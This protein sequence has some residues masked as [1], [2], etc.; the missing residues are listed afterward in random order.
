MTDLLKINNN[1]KT[2][3]SIELCELINRIRKEEGVKAELRHDTLL[4]KIKNE[5]EDVAPKFFGTTINIDKLG[6]EHKYPCYNLPQKE[7]LQVIASESKRVRRRLID[8]IERL[9]MENQEL[10][11]Q[12]VP[13]TFKEALLL[14][15]EQQCQIEEQQKLI[16]EQKPKVEFYDEV[17][18][19][20][21]Y[22]D[23]SE[24][25]KCLNK[26]IGR[27]KL[28]QI[29]REQGILRFNNE[30]YQ[31]YVDNGFFKIET[32]S[33]KKNGETRIYLKTVVSQSGVEFIKKILKTQ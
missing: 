12:K 17:L 13:T 11:Q 8:E 18:K 9:T 19:S 31:K 21:D 20:K 3:S 7:A 24:V 30:P 28:F 5:L 32:N 25:A 6:R 22:V 16:E 15:Y 33:Y 26:N 14:A 23:M 4:E 29:L 1:Q 10:K 27:T 2:I